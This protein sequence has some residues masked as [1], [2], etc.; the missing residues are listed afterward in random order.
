MSTADNPDSTD[1]DPVDARVVPDL[2]R[3][4]APSE[5]LPEAGAPSAAEVTGYTGA[6]VPTFDHIRDKIDRRAATA[7]GAQELAEALAPEPDP[8]HDLRARQRAAKDKLE[9]IRRSMRH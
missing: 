8:A 4:P 2:P 3:V 7:L 5:L 9:Q 6:G 1:T